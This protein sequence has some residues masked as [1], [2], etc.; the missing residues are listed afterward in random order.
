[1]R[2]RKSVP[3]TLVTMITQILKEEEYISALQN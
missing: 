1:M 2:E 3:T